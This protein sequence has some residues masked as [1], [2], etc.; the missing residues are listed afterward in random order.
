MEDSMILL[1][2]VNEDQSPQM[3]TRYGLQHRVGQTGGLA[4]WLVDNPDPAQLEKLRVDFRHRRLRSAAL[5]SKV[6]EP[7][8]LWIA[9]EWSDRLVVERK[10]MHS[11]ES[12]LA[13]WRYTDS[14]R[15]E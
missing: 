8:M 9:A 15:H 11:I 4:I 3:K 14:Y 10:L 1:I 7:Q 2:S 5:V 6:P 12:V 13:S